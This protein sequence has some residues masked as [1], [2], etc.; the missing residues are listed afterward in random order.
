MIGRPPRSTLFP[1]TTLFRSPTVCSWETKVS[2]AGRVSV[3]ATAC[4]L[5]GP[6]LATADV[7]MNVVLAA[8]VAGSGFVIDTS[9]DVLTVVLA[10]LVLLFGAG[11]LVVE[12]VFAVLISLVLLE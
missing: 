2:P 5:L 12:V 3:Q 6:A 4:A 11:S 8:P 9:A 10:V 7:Y 1:F